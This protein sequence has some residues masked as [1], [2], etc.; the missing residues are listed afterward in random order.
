MVW[1]VFEILVNLFQGFIIQQF[2]E[3]RLH[4]S[5][6]HKLQDVLCIMTI[7]LYSSL[8]FILTVPLPD[9]VIFFIPL[10]YAWIIADDPWYVSIFW[11]I[12]LALMFL[13]IISLMIHIF[14]SIPGSSYEKLMATTGFRIIFVLVTNATLTLAVYLTSKM[15]K[16][17]STPYWS[18]FL[19]FLL[20]NIAL[21][22][23][24]ESL[25]A[26]QINTVD[27][28]APEKLSYLGAYLGL[29][30]CI[31]LV[32]YLFNMMFQSMERENRYKVEANA[33]KHAQQYQVELE[34]MYATLVAEKHDMKHHIQVLEEMVRA[35]NSEKAKAYLS[36]YQE[37][38]N[39][40]GIF[41]TGSTGVD[42]LLMAKSLTMKRNHLLF[43]YTPYPLND[44]PVIEP[45]F[46]TIVGN[47]LDNAI[48]GCLRI[49]ESQ[50]QLTIDLTFSRSWDMF[51][52]Y[53][54]NPCN[55][56]TIQMESGRW[57]SSKDREGL[58]G[59]H[60]IGIRSIEHIAKA[61]EGRCAFT[62]KD[63]V[64]SAKVVIPY[65]NMKEQNNP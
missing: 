21:F 41:M 26:L 62:I 11:T 60:A 25:Y 17:Y 37:S 2:M 12:V 6:K 29:C 49:P 38:L 24:E 51:Y 44:L 48:E 7:A 14:S 61:S 42:A 19:L 40:D 56:A 23:V 57:V 4:V 39:S 16:D 65:H 54:T 13:S 43:H 58:A 59:V 34:Q 64:F 1:T 20:T 22:V 27:R 30:A 36:S 53:C 18:V 28:M 50:E 46:C 5:C 55:T 47:L 8:S 10:I 32:V 33:I 9:V 63:G 31:I 3:S 35:G 45:D 52:I 15:K